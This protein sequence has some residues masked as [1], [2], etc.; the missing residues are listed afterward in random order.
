MNKKEIAFTTLKRIAMINKVIIYNNEQLDKGNISS[1]RW[2]NKI[3][4]LQKAE[5]EVKKLAL[6]IL[7]YSEKWMEIIQNESYI[8]WLMGYDNSS[9]DGIKDLS[10]EDFEKMYGKLK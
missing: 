5:H 4:P 10:L 7:G 1:E 6:D 3:T 8:S 2:L 9:D